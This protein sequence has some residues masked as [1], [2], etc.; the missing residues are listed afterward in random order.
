[1]TARREAVS[2]DLG[3]GATTQQVTDAVIAAI[4]GVN[5]P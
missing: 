4:R 1:V 3:G 5:L 2:P